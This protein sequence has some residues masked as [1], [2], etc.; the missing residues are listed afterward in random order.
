MWHTIQ[1][2]LVLLV[3]MG[4]LFTLCACGAEDAIPETTGNIAASKPE[5][6]TQPA[7]TEQ[8]TTEEQKPDIPA[9]MLQKSGTFYAQKAQA[10]YDNVILY[11]DSSGRGIINNLAEGLMDTKHEYISVMSEKYV[12]FEDTGYVKGVLTIAGEEIFASDMCFGI[13]Y[14]GADYILLEKMIPCEEDDPRKA[15]QERGGA[16][17]RL[18]ISVY[19]L[20]EQKTVEEIDLSHYTNMSTCEATEDNVMVYGRIAD[21]TTV[22]E[23]FFFGQDRKIA[24]NSPENWLEGGRAVHN[25]NILDSKG[26]VILDFGAFDCR[27]LQVATKTDEYY[28]VSKDDHR[29]LMD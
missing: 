6:Q 16:C 2:L 4:M 1:K 12:R 18:D 20:K 24:L 17:Y 19:S 28:L 7:Q 21:G 26:N 15:L 9:L 27:L 10:K 8:E 11:E 23:V 22:V 25:G 14:L 29:A 5:Q 3:A 13:Q